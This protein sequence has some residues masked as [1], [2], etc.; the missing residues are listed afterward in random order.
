MSIEEARARER[1]WAYA[2]VVLYLVAIIL[3]IG[4][5]VL[6]VTGHTPPGILAGAGAFVSVIFSFL[7]GRASIKWLKLADRLEGRP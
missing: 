7:A 2:A 4:G 5:F 6:A 1:R 3:G